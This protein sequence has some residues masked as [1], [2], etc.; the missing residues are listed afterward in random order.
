LPFGHHGLTLRPE[1]GASGITRNFAG[2]SDTSL[3]QCGILAAVGRRRNLPRGRGPKAQ[4]DKY[5][6]F[7]TLLNAMDGMSTAS[8]L[9]NDR[10]YRTEVRQEVLVSIPASKHKLFL[11][12]CSFAKLMAE[13]GL[14]G[15]TDL[16]VNDHGTCCR[17]GWRT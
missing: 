3:Y 8:R 5:R 13:V 6:S 17:S 15:A 1:D 10:P 7:R 11:R 12:H 14:H 9:A 4:P 2:L 16:S